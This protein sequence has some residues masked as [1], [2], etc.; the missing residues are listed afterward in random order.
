MSGNNRIWAR[1]LAL[2]IATQ[3]PDCE[4]DALE[5]L[6]YARE[7][8]SYVSEGNKSPPKKLTLVQPAED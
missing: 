7:L 6:R 5:V 1:R 3:L 2:Q 4:G 8:I